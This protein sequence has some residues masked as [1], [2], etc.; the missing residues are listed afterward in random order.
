MLQTL[1]TLVRGVCRWVEKGGPDVK[2][3]VTR[4]G[5]ASKSDRKEQSDCTADA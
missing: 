1:S 3:S 5:E 2:R 4:G